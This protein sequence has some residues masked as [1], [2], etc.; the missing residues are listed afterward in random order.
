MK[1]KKNRLMTY[2]IAREK[3]KKNWPKKRPAVG[4]E[5]DVG[6]KG[7]KGRKKKI[8]PLARGGKKNGLSW[9]LGRRKF[10]HDAAG[11][12][13]VPEEGGKKKNF[14]PRPA[15]ETQISPERPLKKKPMGQPSL[16]E[17]KET[18]KLEREK[19][20]ALRRKLAT[21]PT[22]G[23]QQSGRKKKNTTHKRKKKTAMSLPRGEK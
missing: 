1:K 18:I 14:L 16:E 2:A 6:K 23:Q 3:T 8:G 4:E 17:K 10:W 22:T 11:K 20:I 21:W 13:K 19:C 5:R 12:K 15:T 9:A 7:T